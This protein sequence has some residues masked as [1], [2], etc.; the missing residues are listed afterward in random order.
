M[1][2]EHL[3]K[4]SDR[5]A[6]LHGHAYFRVEEGALKECLT[7]IILDA[8]E[9]DLAEQ[10]ASGAFDLEVSVGIQEGDSEATVDFRVDR[11]GVVYRA[12]ALV[13]R[14]SVP[15][16]EDLARYLE[17]LAN[18]AEVAPVVEEK[19]GAG[20]IVRKSQDHDH[21]EKEAAAARLKVTPQWLKS[22]VPCTDYSY[23]E[24][25]GK[26]YIREYYWSRELIE[27]LFKIK[28]SKTTP[29]DLQYVAK[30]CCD[31]D[32]EWA[33]ELIARLKSPNRPEPQQKEQQK[34]QPQR[35]KE[36]GAAQQQA[37]PAAGDRPRGRSRHRK[38]FRQG[39][40]GARK[41]EGAADA[42]KP[43]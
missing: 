41:G 25:D 33:R 30:E 3:Q 34:N 32:A 18:Q 5:L 8:V 7:G 11:P 26:K 12:D 28:T 22:V 27:R 17:H 15:G 6:R 13:S 16:L 39:K 29:E 10:L 14:L 21:H 38:S 19:G 9:G 1:T 24:I 2:S 35:E 36:K 31:G 23:D 4:I 43:S 42:K 40:D 20:N 37:K